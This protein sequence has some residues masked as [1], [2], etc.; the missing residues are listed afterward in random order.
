MSGF[1]DAAFAGAGALPGLELWRIEKGV[2]TKTEANGKFHKGDSYILLST[3]QAP[4][5]SA[6]TWD[7]H[8]WLGSESSQDEIGIC[9]YKTVELD[10]S[11]GG[12]PVQYREVEGGESP[13]FLSYFK[14]SGIEYLP[15]GIESGFTKVDR[16]AYETRLL[17]VKGKRTVRCTS[18]AI[19]N[20]S[21]N[22]GDCF[23]LDMGKSLYL[24]NGRDANKH[25]KAKAV[26]TAIAI[27][28]N[29]RGGGAT[30]TIINEDPD[31]EAFWE[32]LG[33]KIEVTNP[34][35]DDQR[36]ERKAELNIKMFK[37]SDAS[38]SVT[39]EKVDEGKLDKA[40]LDTSDTFLVD[41]GSSL[42]VWVGRGSTA[43]EK[44]EGMMR[45]NSYLVDNNMP[46]TTPVS[47]VVEGA[48][49]TIFKSLFGQWNPP[50]KF[51]FTQ[52][53][54]S[55]VAKVEQKDVDVAAMHARKSADDKPVDDGSGIV[56]VWRVED[57]KKVEVD[58]ATLGQF[59]GGDSYVILYTYQKNGVEEYIIYFWQGRESSQD[60]KGA[61]ALLAKEL[62][63][64]LKDRPVQVRVVQ[65]KEP[66]HFRAMFHG[67]MIIRAGGKASG[68]KNK[69]DSDSYDVDGTELYHVKGTT[70]D[71]TYGV[72]IKEAATELNSG[73]CFVLL[74]PE[75]TYVWSGSGSNDAEKAAAA[76][77][78]EVIKSGPVEAISEG[79]EPEEFWTALGG[80]ADYPKMRPGEPEPA[81]PRLFQLSNATGTF[82]VEEICNFTQDD[83][84]DDDVMLLD[85]FS[86]VF[87]WIGHNANDAEKKEAVKTAQQYVATANDGRDD[88]TPIMVVKAGREPNL[89][90]QHFLGWDDDFYEKN[91]FVDPY[92]AKLDSM[93]A[94]QKEV[95]EEEPIIIQKD[96]DIGEALGGVKAG[97][98]FT[99]AELQGGKVEGIDNSKKEEYLSDADFQEAFG[100]DKAAFAGLA[101]WKQQGAKKKAGIF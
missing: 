75:K 9:A 47:R 59:F 56:Q 70:A 36:A 65:G 29:E 79:G 6:L 15:G 67:E 97:T 46:H 23:I 55:G 4:T 16:D 39:M 33:G 73:D 48:E 3:K 25:E 35:E 53:P 34:G 42:I 38:G 40:L 60:E 51:D 80:K 86:S 32:A 100:M 8:F 49:T 77:I 44:K 96:S 57:F 69:N 21:L 83:L 98:T 89:F 68:F 91:K 19:S 76:S 50:I 5:S 24:Y 2:P 90:S 22:T 27:R 43:T 78:A 94:T 63:D 13:Q 93:K 10:E 30:I 87:L 14:S 82:D 52:P 85:C 26:E 88:D 41:T 66:A 31:N 20:A 81:D 58:D 92:A 72:Q 54:S 101:K 62:D 18:V 11:L 28:D 12:G 84:V 7:I 1:T 64:E 45:A 17:Q 37:I 61:S 95:E 74:V 71:N 99:L